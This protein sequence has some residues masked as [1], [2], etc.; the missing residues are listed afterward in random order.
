[1]VQYQPPQE[2]EQWTEWLAVGL[3]GRNCWRL[4]PILLGMLFACGRRTVSSWLRAGSVHDDFASYYSFLLPV[5]RK[6]LELALR[7]FALLLVR[8]PL[9]E[10]LLLVVDDS[11]TKRYGPKV[12]GA[13]IHRN[14]TPGPSDQKFL[15]GHIWV[16]ISLAIRHP[17]WGT[18]SL[19]LLGMLYVRAKDIVKIPARCQW[20]FRTKLKLAVEALLT[21]LTLAKSVGKKVWVVADGAYANGPFLKPLRRVGVVVVSRLRKNAHLNTLPPKQKPGQRRG[22]GRPPTYGKG[23]RPKRTGIVDRHFSALVDW[24]K[25]RRVECTQTLQKP[26]RMRVG[27]DGNDRCFG[28]EY[29]QRAYR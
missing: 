27:A 21:F 4:S 22:P 8:L 18:M 28:G 7:L 9:G 29:P 14:P 13:G 5:G 23:R 11:P 10:R 3:H 25:S 20:P 24:P 1:M 6:A 2:W 16:T 17:L 26:E 19:P 15:C 12:Q